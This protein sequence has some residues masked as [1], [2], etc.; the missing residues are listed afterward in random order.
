LI[1]NVCLLNFYIQWFINQHSPP[2]FITNAIHFFLTLI[3]DPS[4]PWNPVAPHL[5]QLARS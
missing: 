4:H 5:R 3:S 2:P 1:D